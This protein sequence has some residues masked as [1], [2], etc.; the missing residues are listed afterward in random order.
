VELDHKV[1]SIADS[2]S[3]LLHQPRELFHLS[4][5]LQWLGVRHEH[6]LHSRVAAV[7]HLQSKLDQ[8]FHFESFIDRFHDAAAEMRVHAHPVA[9]PATEQLI[10]GDRQNFSF[11][12]PECLFDRRNRAHADDP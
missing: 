7:D 3:K 8:R 12:V 4:N 1:D 11:D 2:S 10:D 6:D 9:Y 5:P